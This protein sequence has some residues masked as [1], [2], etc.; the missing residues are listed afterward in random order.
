MSACLEHYLPSG[1]SFNSA[2]SSRPSSKV[3]PHTPRSQTFAYLAVTA[4]IILKTG[5]TFCSSG[6][7]QCLAQGQE[8]AKYYLF[9][10]IDEGR[11]W[12]GG[13]EEWQGVLL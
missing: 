7:N 6:Y 5:T 4:D 2:Y 13:W 10:W 1:P 3:T 8:H 9:L 11:S 12:L